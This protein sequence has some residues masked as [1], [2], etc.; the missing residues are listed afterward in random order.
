M[1]Q[2]FVSKKQRDWIVDLVQEIIQSKNFLLILAMK[3]HRPTSSLNKQ[4][5]K[6]QVSIFLSMILSIIKI[7]TIPSIHGLGRNVV[8]VFYSICKKTVFHLNLATIVIIN[9]PQVRFH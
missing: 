3:L 7:Q 8:P 5:A 1:P 9:Y 2:P 4:T 6:H